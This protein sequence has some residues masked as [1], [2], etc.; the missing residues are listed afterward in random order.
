MRERN[1]GSTGC[2]CGLQAMTSPWVA[3]RDVLD[4]GGLR[5]VLP[6]RS[7]SVVSRREV[8]EDAA[9]WQRRDLERLSQIDP[10]A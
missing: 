3:S 9:R 8:T 5:I 4:P 2:D 6:D 1:R 10:A 7:M